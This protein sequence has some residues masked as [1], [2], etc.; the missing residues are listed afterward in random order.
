MELVS[1]L[2]LVKPHCK[3]HKVGFLL[4]Q[5]FCLGRLS[6]ERRFWHA[7][8][9]CILSVWQWVSSQEGR[10]CHS[11]VVFFSMKYLLFPAPSLTQSYGSVE[12]CH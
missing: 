12:N 5:G 8:S 3:E 9:P 6:T 2:S 1:A 11:F 7:E 4:K 10:L